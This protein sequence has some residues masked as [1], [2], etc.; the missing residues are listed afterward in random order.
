MRFDLSTVVSI[1]LLQE[2]V[3]QDISRF[4][5]E[6]NHTNSLIT[7]A[8]VGEL[9]SLLSCSIDEITYFYSKLKFNLLFLMLYYNILVLFFIA[10][11]MFSIHLSSCLQ[12]LQAV[13]KNNES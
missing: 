8:A 1:Y 5:F 11:I 2:S 3:F 13:L 12:D 6:G 4:H 7:S 10:Y 9:C